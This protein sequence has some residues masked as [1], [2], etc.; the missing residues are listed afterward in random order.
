VGTVPPRPT[1]RCFGHIRSI[2]SYRHSKDFRNDKCHPHNQ[3]GI[4]SGRHGS[5][6]RDNHITTIIV[7]QRCYYYC[8]KSSL[9][10]G[11]KSFGRGR[12]G[13]EEDRNRDREDGERLE[14]QRSAWLSL[15]YLKYVCGRREKSGS[16]VRSP[17]KNE[18][19][20]NAR[21]PVR[22]CH[23]CKYL[24]LPYTFLAVLPNFWSEFV[25]NSLRRPTYN[26]REQRVVPANNTFKTCIL[27]RQPTISTIL[28]GTYKLYKSLYCY[29]QPTSQLRQVPPQKI[30]STRQ[31]LPGR[32]SSKVRCVYQ[33]PVCVCDYCTVRYT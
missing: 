21:R 19:H 13:E 20:A 31:I 16:Q 10:V 30:R 18:N 22:N 12:L 7:I 15:S 29:I 11:K 24:K 6:P 9:C 2:P 14:A 27:C 28:P 4:D 33:V 32:T 17:F 8:S 1:K 3:Q 23:T 26:S 25:A 5:S